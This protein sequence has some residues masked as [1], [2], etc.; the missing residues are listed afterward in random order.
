MGLK[1]S[2]RL[3]TPT[4]FPFF[5]K[6]WLHHTGMKE[7]S[8]LYLR[9]A[10]NDTYTFWDSPI[11]FAGIS[12]LLNENPRIFPGVLCPGEHESPTLPSLASG[13]FATVTAAASTRR[14]AG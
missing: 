5:P 2:A 13:K 6:G 1:E 3:C 14:T 4:G 8:S 9:F 12:D 10:Q 11:K 7:D